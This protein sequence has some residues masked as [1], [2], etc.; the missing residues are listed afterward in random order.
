MILYIDKEDGEPSSLL[1]MALEVEAT[2]LGHRL[3][4][5]RDQHQELLQ[6]NH[7]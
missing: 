3:V 7:H 6:L 2:D 4:L 5:V 1:S